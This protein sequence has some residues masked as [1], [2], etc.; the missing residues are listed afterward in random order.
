M[1]I[2]KYLRF[3]TN[4]IFDIYRISMLYQTDIKKYLRFSTNIIFYVMVYQINIKNVLTIFH[5]DHILCVSYLY[6]E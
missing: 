1:H 3:S 4:I 5:L 2:K 6:V